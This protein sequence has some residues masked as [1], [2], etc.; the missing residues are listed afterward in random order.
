MFAA[1]TYLG[2]ISRGF[3]VWT[4]VLAISGGHAAAWRMCTL[5]CGH[6]DLL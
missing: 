3:A 6:C 5:F 1:T 4:T 2:A